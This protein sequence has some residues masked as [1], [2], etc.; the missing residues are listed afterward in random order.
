M[1]TTVCLYLVTCVGVTEAADNN[2]LEMFM[3]QEH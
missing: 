2:R 1:N 3:K